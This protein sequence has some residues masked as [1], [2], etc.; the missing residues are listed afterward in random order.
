VEL[1]Q[2]SERT[3][4]ENL[5]LK[6]ENKQFY[7]EKLIMDAREHEI[8]QNLEDAQKLIKKYREEN[9]SITIGNQSLAKR[10]ESANE[11]IKQL[12]NANYQ[13]QNANSLQDQL[14]IT[15]S[16]ESELE[17]ERKVRAT[18]EN[19]NKMM[20]SQIKALKEKSQNLIDNLRRRNEQNEADIEKL[21]SDNAELANQIQSLKS[22]IKNNLSVQEDLVK[23]NQSLQVKKSLF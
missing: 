13:M 14:V 4:G 18:V 9:I 11:T 15:Q 12:Q 22:D 19:E 8:P 20:R 7:G 23:L 5:K 21:K 6:S 3:R 2:E 17:R 16:L 10:L 1:I